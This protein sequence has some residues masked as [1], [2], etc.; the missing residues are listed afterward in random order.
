MVLIENC[1]RKSVVDNAAS[2]SRL[3]HY[4]GPKKWIQQHD[5]EIAEIFLNLF[6][7]P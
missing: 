4:C 6:R 2:I 5:N 1:R 3:Q 7:G